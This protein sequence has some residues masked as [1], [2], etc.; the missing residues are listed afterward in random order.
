MVDY[1]SFVFGL[2]ETLEANNAA[3]SQ[4]IDATR[5]ELG[6]INKRLDRP[7]DKRNDV[8][9]EKIAILTNTTSS[10]TPVSPSS[11]ET[12]FQR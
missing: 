9:D 7:G 4:R 3:Y 6:W 10:T 2:A 11:L 1:L 8:P 5:S 12:A